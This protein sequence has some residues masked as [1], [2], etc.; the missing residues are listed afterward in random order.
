MQN[1]IIT[2]KLHYRRKDEQ[3]LQ[4]NAWIW[5]LN[6]RG[7]G[8]EFLEDGDD[9]TAT[10]VF[11]G[12]TTTSVSFII[13][14]GEWEAQEFG[15]RRIDV[16]TVLSG[17]VHCYVDEG[18]ADFKVL[19]DT[20]VEQANKLLSV[21]LDYD[22]GLLLVQTAKP[23]TDLNEFNLVLAD[24]SASDK[25]IISMQ[26]SDD[27]YA[28]T[29]SKPLD[30]ITLYL[31]KLRFGSIDYAIHTTSV[32]YSARFQKEYTYDGQVPLGLGLENDWRRYF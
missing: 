6:Q 29:L 8:Y 15:E 21:E 9:M 30:L 23:I 22:T 32:Y 3:Y 12:Y 1:K 14:K 31:Y 19:L 26:K 16:S 11:D 25:E 4:W 17:T 20:D 18:K 10:V 7:S 5:T 27:K 2:V 13:R 24:G 28:L